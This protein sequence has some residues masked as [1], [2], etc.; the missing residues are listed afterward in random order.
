MR[1]TNIILILLQV[2][3][4]LALDHFF[5]VRVKSDGCVVKK[6]NGEKIKETVKR[7]F[8]DLVIENTYIFRRKREDALNL[9]LNMYHLTL[10]WISIFCYAFMKKVI[11]YMFNLKSSAPSFNRFVSPTRARFMCKGCEDMNRWLITFI[12]TYNYY[13]FHGSV[14]PNIYCIFQ[15]FRTI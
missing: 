7:V 5:S 3:T 2:Q 10:H 15:C 1:L 9:L 4:L 12:Y 11:W 8:V 14:L 6:V 13:L